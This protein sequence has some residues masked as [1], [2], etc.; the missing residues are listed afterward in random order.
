MNYI[1]VAGSFLFGKGT[2]LKGQEEKTTG[3]NR[4]DLLIFT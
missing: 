1:I 2:I 3:T 4:F